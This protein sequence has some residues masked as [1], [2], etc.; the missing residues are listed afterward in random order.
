MQKKIG[1][2][3]KAKEDADDLLK[4]KIELEKEKKSLVDSAAEKDKL[5]KAKVKTV[6]NYVHDSV[7]VSDN[8]VCNQS[9]VRSRQKHGA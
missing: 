3:K 1:A 8:E 2:K 5:L 6:G 7:P 9:H 4:E